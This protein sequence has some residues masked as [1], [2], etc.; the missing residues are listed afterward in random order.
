[1]NQTLSAFV[2]SLTPPIVWNAYLRWRGRPPTFPWHT[3]GSIATCV[4][5]APLLEGKFAEIYNK[6]CSVG[7]ESCRSGQT[8]QV[9][10]IWYISRQI[11]LRAAARRQ[12]MSRYYRRC[13]MGMS[14]DD[15]ANVGK[16]SRQSAA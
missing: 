6:Y 7:N 2:H 3:F 13:A 9:N 1:M 14:A 15:H 8:A 16:H 4:D 11:F 10:G 12:R 5:D